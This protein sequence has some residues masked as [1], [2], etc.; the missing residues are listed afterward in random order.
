MKR[1]SLFGYIVDLNCI[2][3]WPL[4]ELFERA[5]KHTKECALRGKSIESGYAIVCDEQTVAF[6]DIEATPLIL[7]A[8]SLSKLQIGIAVR[9]ER[10]MLHDGSMK[11]ILVTE[12]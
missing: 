9:V 1:E 2:R 6:L 12:S 11:T 7:E 3:S 5:G 4:S 8:I 10:E